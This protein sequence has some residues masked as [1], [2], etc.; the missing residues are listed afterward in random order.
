MPEQ[1]HTAGPTQALLIALIAVTPVFGQGGRQ[2]TTTRS[3]SRSSGFLDAV[4]HLEQAY[5]DQV[6]RERA[7][8]T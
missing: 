7:R 3:G 8:S 4:R 2:L 1:L 5:V 6:A